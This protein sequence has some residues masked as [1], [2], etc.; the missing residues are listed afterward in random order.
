MYFLW[1]Y[2][3]PNV[4]VL[5]AGHEDRGS[6]TI[7]F[8]DG[9]GEAVQVDEDVLQDGSSSAKRP[10]LIHGILMTVTWAI[11]LPSSIYAA[12]NKKTFLGGNG[13]WIKY[14][15]ACAFFALIFQVVAYLLVRGA[16]MSFGKASEVHVPLGTFITVSGCI[17]MPLLGVFRPPAT[18]PGED[19][20]AKRKIWE[21]SQP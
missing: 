17:I 20:T 19:I 2:G 6:V 10:I 7:N 11:I 5:G 4:A 18:K 21:V 13:A 8:L 15:K 14:H 1:A 16:D 3:Y 9:V 12:L